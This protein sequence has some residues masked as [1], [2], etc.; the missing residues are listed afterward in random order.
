MGFLSFYAKKALLTLP[1]HLP[2]FVDMDD[3]LQLVISCYPLKIMEG[4]HALKPVR[5]ISSAERALLV[6]LFRKL[7]QMV[8]ASPATKK[9]PMVQMSLSKLIVV[10]VGYCWNEFKEDDWEFL[11]YQCRLWIESSVVMMEEMSEDVNDAIT[12]LSTANNMEV[13]LEKLKQAVSRVNLSPT[14]YARNALVSF[15][16]FCRLVKLHMTGHLDGSATLKSDKWDLVMHRI[17]ESVLRLFFSTGVAEAIASSYCYEASTIIASARLDHSHFWELVAS[18]VVDSSPHS[19]DRA[20][21]SVEMWG[22]SKGPISS[23]YAILFS[24][25]PVPCLQFAAY[26]MLSSETVSQLAFVKENPSPPGDDGTTDTQNNTHLK[27]SSEDNDL[28]REEI[29]FMLIRSPHDVLDSDLM[30]E[31][32]VILP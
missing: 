28:L 6:E 31:K 7:R 25:K 30:A 5:N 19:R 21:K 4:T 23:L 10:L 29:F 9:L 11:L 1:S 27:S 32:R 20:V 15:S 18:Y 12:N 8:G 14:I 26:V 22:L 3:W 2:I 16:I 13:T 24:S 17:I